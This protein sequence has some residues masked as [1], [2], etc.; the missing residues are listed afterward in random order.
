MQIYR[1]ETTVSDNGTLT[2]DK[3]PFRVGDEVEV[4][5]R[6]RKRARESTARYPLRGE[7][8][9]YSEPFASVAEDDWDALQ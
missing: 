5:V 4:V 7:P 9:C 1:V 8:L 6:A 3:L 2:L